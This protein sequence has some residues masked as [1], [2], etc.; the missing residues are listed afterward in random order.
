MR[1]GPHL[2][3]LNRTSD[4]DVFCYEMQGTFILVLLLENTGSVATCLAVLRLRPGNQDGGACWS[5]KQFMRQLVEKVAQPGG[6]VQRTAQTGR[7]IRST[8]L[9]YQT[10]SST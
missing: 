7:I 9:D 1:A 6:D 4:Q 2:K 3:P 10:T 8:S 5:S